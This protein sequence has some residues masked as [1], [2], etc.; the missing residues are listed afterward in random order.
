MIYILKLGH[1]SWVQ[2]DSPKSTEFFS[3]PLYLHPLASVKKNEDI[4]WGSLSNVALSATKG[5]SA[6]TDGQTKH[7]QT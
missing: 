5:N 4:F 3:Y 6:T 2:L 7:R 1:V